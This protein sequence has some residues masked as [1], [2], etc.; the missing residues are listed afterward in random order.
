[1]TEPILI[2]DNHLELQIIEQKHPELKS[3]PLI[4]LSSNFSLKLLEEFTSRGYTYFDEPITEEDAHRLSKEMQHFIYTWF[5]DKKGNDLSLIEGCSLGSAFASSLEILFNSLLRYITGLRKLLIKNHKV[6]YTSLTEDIFLDVIVY[7]HREIGFTLCPVETNLYKET[8]THGNRKL[9]ID[10][11]GRKRDLSVFF[12]WQEKWKKKIVDF[13]LRNFQAKSQCEKRVLI[14]PAGKLETYFEHVCENVSSEGFR[15]ILPVSLSGLRYLFKRRRK[16]PLFYYF[17]A[18]D[19]NRSAEIDPLLQQLKINLRE[20]ITVI[21][22]ELLITLMERH[23]FCYFPGALNFFHSALKM[24]Q[25]LQPDLAIFSA[26]CYENFTLAAQAA[27]K[28][29]V[30]TAILQHGL[31]GWGNPQTKSGRFQLFEYGLAFGQVDVDNYI[32]E[33]MPEEKVVITSFPFF[34][35]FLP[36][37]KKNT[38]YKYQKV[39]LLQPDFSNICPA[40]KLSSEYRFYTEICKLLNEMDIGIIGIKSRH[41]FNFRNLGLV[42][43][44]LEINGKTIPL[45]GEFSSFNDVVKD[46]DFVIGPGGTS[47]IEASLLGKDYYMYNHIVFQESYASTCFAIFDYINISNTMEQLR[48]NILKRQPYKQGCSVNDLI[49][50]EGVKTKEDLFDKFESGIQAVLDD[51]ATSKKEPYQEPP[52]P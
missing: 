43:D 17:S 1:M 10:T 25:L 19:S 20:L 47:L 44:W 11:T 51:L 40:E 5:L 49:D 28:E 52:R 32:S 18:T 16:A 46:A 30:K 45:L 21:D 13:L 42:K 7:L 15:W 39:L 14:M 31:Y 24:F 33:G 4:L 26:D 27:K 9:K 6:F 2:I 41:L 35:K 50:L 48:E 22:P 12:L 36:F 37:K 23:T 29:K 3:A 34:E 38:S 8:I